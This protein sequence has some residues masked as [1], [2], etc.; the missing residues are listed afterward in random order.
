MGRL[1][2]GEV[3]EGQGPTV[4]TQDAGVRA[5]TVRLPS[6]ALGRILRV[7]SPSREWSWQS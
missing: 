3:R 2:G 7:W 1:G 6:A 5:G 4:M